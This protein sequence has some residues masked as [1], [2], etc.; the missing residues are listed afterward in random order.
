ML[1]DARFKVAVRVPFIAAARQYSAPFGWEGVELEVPVGRLEV[2][3]TYNGGRPARNM[4]VFLNIRDYS[5]GIT[6]DNGVIRIDVPA[7]RNYRLR[8]YDSPARWRFFS[9]NRF[10]VEDGQTLHLDVNLDTRHGW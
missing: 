6:D 8:V 3:F 4:E 5:I 7:A 1:P 9:S 10:N 2:R